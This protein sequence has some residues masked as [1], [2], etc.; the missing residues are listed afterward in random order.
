MARKRNALLD[1]AWATM[2][3]E[4]IVGKIANEMVDAGFE[5]DRYSGNMGQIRARVKETR[6]LHGQGKKRLAAVVLEM[7]RQRIVRR[8][9]K[10]NPPIDWSAHK[11]PSLTSRRSHIYMRLTGRNESCKRLARING[12]LVFLTNGRL[13]ILR[14]EDM[15]TFTFGGYPATIHAALMSYRNDE[16]RQ[17]LNHGGSVSFDF[18]AHE[19]I[20][21]VPWKY[22]AFKR[23]RIRW[24][25]PKVLRLPQT[26]VA[27]R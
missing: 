4:G 12:E 3:E 14:G 8:K 21:R 9:R 20:L 11:R 23:K 22:G 26:C 16:I 25:A 15:L 1:L 27:G 17:V 24:P 7:P 19:T 6:P 13:V 10:A 5:W 2:G 18:A